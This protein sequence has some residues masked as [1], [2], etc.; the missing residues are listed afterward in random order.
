MCCEKHC[1]QDERTETPETPERRVL[2]D[3]GFF[4]HFIYTRRGGRGGKQHVL[5]TLYYADGQMTQRVLLEKTKTTS[6]SLSEVVGKLESAGL[7][8]RERSEADRRQLVVRLTDE[9][10]AR[11]EAVIADKERFEHDAFSCLGPG[12][13]DELLGLLDRLHD[14]WERLKRNEDERG[15]T[16]W[17]KN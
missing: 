1:A 8:E 14:H 4:G 13:L 17:L 7:V 6:A 11:A 9:G 15:D 3:I 2:H 12:E 16:V 5:K 10:R